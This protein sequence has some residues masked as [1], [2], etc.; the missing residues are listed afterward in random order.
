MRNLR[1]KMRY[2]GIP[3]TKISK[4]LG[5]SWALVYQV[6]TGNRTDHYQIRKIALELIREKLR[7]SSGSIK[8]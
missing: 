6:L 5:I 1:E 7:E 8:S 2:H 4:P 3:L